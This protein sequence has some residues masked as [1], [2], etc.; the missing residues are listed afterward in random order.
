MP[1]VPGPTYSQDIDVLHPDPDRVLVEQTLRGDLKAF[2]E[3]FARHRLAVFG[4]ARRIVG[5]EEAL[6]VSQETFLRGFHNLA[7]FRGESSFRS[8]L[9]R[10]AHN[11]AVD[12]AAHRTPIPVDSELEQADDTDTPASER[13]PAESL[14]RRECHERMDLLLETMRPSYRDLLV[15]RDVEG[16]PYEEIARILEIP[17]GS[18][19]GRLHRARHELIELLRSN[20]YEWDLPLVA[21]A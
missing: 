12:V 18:V 20:V 2:A 16:R 9:L 17:L 13:R 6:D 19:K 14:E 7:S 8:W 11:S 1:E 10:I 5:P 21:A 15:L 4:L 3:L